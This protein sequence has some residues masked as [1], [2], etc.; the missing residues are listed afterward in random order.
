VLFAA[1]TEDLKYFAAN[2]AGQ[3]LRRCVVDFSLSNPYVVV[4]LLFGGLL[5]YL[6]GGIVD[7]GCRPRRRCGG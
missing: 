1:Y 6:F 5:P 4:G 2:A 7:D 3:L